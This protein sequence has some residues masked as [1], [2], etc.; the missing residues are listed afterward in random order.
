MKTTYKIHP[1][2]DGTFEVLRQ[3]DG[4]SIRTMGNFASRREAERVK[5]AL[6]GKAVLKIEGAG[7]EDGED[8]T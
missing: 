8:Q 2:T 1:I 6:E 3:A 7:D 5:S 4:K